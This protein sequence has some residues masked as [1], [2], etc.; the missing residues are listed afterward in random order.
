MDIIK[1]LWIYAVVLAIYYIVLFYSFAKGG[2]SVGKALKSKQEIRENDH[3]M[4]R[5]PEQQD[6]DEELDEENVEE[7]E[8]DEVQMEIKAEFIDLTEKCEY[9]EGSQEVIEEDLI[10][11]I[12][13]GSLVLDDMPDSQLL[14]Y[15]GP[16]EENK[17]LDDQND[18]FLSNDKLVV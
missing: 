12:S 9:E 18:D 6:E 7:E 1:I 13:G 3:Q 16:E 5:E 14:Q 10:V 4:T 17:I 15:I 8:S 11:S 2:V